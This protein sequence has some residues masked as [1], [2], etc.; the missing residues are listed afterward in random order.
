V[1][2]TMSP[3]VGMGSMLSVSLLFLLFSPGF[4]SPFLI[5]IDLFHLLSESGA[6]DFT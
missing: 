4:A 1:A 2:V 5:W 6:G 3:S